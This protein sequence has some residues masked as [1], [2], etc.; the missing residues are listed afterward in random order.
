MCVYSPLQSCYT[1]ISQS[2]HSSH[3]SLINP[4]LLMETVA[5]HFVPQHFLWFGDNDMTGYRGRLALQH[6]D[7]LYLIYCLSTQCCWLWTL[8]TLALWLAAGSMSWADEFISVATLYLWSVL[9]T[10]EVNYV[11][12]TW[13]LYGIVMI[14]PSISKTLMCCQGNGVIACLKLY[15]LTA[16]HMKIW[17]WVQNFYETF[18][19]AFILNC[20]P[21]YKQD[22]SVCVKRFWVTQQ[23]QNTLRFASGGSLP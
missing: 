6:T 15:R 22:S 11:F 23:R 2:S 4:R 12:I 8:L 17:F 14:F 3:C 20:W 5:C 7:K 16:D 18:V 10:G 21:W 9:F 1:D 19:N 13:G